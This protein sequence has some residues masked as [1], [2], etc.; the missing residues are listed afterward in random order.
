MNLKNENAKKDVHLAYF[1]GNNTVYLCD[2]ESIAKYLSTEYPNNK[3]TNQRGGKK[4]DKRK[5]NDS[6]SEDK[7]SNTGGTA[8]AHVENTTTNETSN[9]PSRKASLDAHISETNQP[10]SRPSR[11]VDEILGAY[12]VNDDFWDNTNPTDVSIDT[13]NNEEKMAG[14]YITKFHTYEDEQP[15]ITDLLSQENQD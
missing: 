7:D 6:K 14:S 3:P 12:P 9:A 10:L 11:T 13:A 1:Q 15:V 2:I 8:G 4:G 5:G